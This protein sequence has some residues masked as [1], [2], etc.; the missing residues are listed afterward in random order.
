MPCEEMRT[1]DVIGKKYE[2]EG[3]RHMEER[4]RTEKVYHKVE[5][6]SAIDSAVP[7]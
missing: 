1:L 3:R 5:P 4:T 2:G 6:R 7:V